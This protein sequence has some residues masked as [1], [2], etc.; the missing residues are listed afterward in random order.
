VRTSLPVAVVRRKVAE[1]FSPAEIS[2]LALWLDASSAD[3]LYTTDAGPVTAVSSPTEIAGCVGWWDASDSASIT[4]SGG[5]V[6]QWNDKSGQN[7]HATASGSARPTLT[8]G[9]L[10]GRSVMTFDGSANAMTVAANS[11]FNSSDLT[12]FIVFRQAS[13][14]NKGVY[15][16]LSA[17]AG[18][19]GFGF[20]VRSDPQI[21]MLQKNA[22]SAQVLTSTANPTTQ[23]R[24]Y[25]V[26]SSTSAAG[27]LDGVTAVAASGQSAD[28]SLNQA[29]TIGARASSEYL[30]G[31]IAEIIH[32]NT[33]LSTAD[34]ARVEAYLAQRWGISGVHAQATASS[35]P[36]G[37]WADKSGNARHATQSTAASRPTISAT[38]RNNR[39]VAQFASASS[40][41]LSAD[42]LSSVVTGSDVPMTAIAVCLASPSASTATILGF[43][44][45]STDAPFF[46]LE[47]TVNDAIGAR[48]RDDASSLV[49]A[50]ASGAS[51]TS[52]AVASMTFAGQ[53]TTLSLNGA[54][55]AKNASLDCG[56]LSLTTA[57]I[58]ALR[59]TSVVTPFA[60]NIAELL[61]YSRAVSSS[62]RRRLE[63]YLANRWGITLAP[64]VSNADAQ[65]WINRV[66]ANGGS[67]SASTASAVNTLC[68][69]LDAASLR[70][71]FYRLNLFCGTGLNACLVP[72]YRGPSLGGTQYGNTT[73]TNVGPF[74]S[75]DYS[76][77]A[78]LQSLAST[79]YLNTGLATDA[80]PASVYESM[81]LSAWHGPT[82]STVSS[83]Q[84]L[85]VYNGTTDRWSISIGVS[86]SSALSDQARLGKANALSSTTTIQGSRPSAF[87][88]A[89]RTSATNLVLYRNA[90]SDGVL[91]TSVTG[92]ASSNLPFYV[93][94]TNLS[95]TDFGDPGVYA[96]R[97][98]SI[99]DDMTQQQ[100]ASFHA[101][102]S[103]FN[104]A[105]GRTA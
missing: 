75:G 45:S 103:A 13:A 63:V 33:A 14:A 55:V 71:R 96:M 1:D 68:D 22:G 37:Y 27:Y 32:F 26:T 90:V 64:Q 59:R 9:G 52:W 62:E 98:Y 19:L 66:Y 36:V 50:T 4:Q 76:E 17:T 102:L 15:T 49:S 6:S 81:H 65:D 83:P 24:V 91:S 54:D 10:N 53:S 29:V 20:V 78:G 101:A 58:G 94:R 93:F 43:G 41:T 40:Q 44:N 21:W 18:T 95:G 67:V 82:Q 85:G 89:T 11:A 31:Y 7:N 105:L 47:K 100:V 69:S 16:K 34:R 104:T 86:T 60:S 46:V 30:N 72:L 88:L 35:D 42:S 56:T 79:K 12:Y 70:D 57:N 92:I 5:L 39:R 23:A 84:L 99:G 28:H 3:T 8:A 74:V 73:D 97:M 2:G 61:V 51:L 48:R 87:L 77:G 38:L 80:M 25:S